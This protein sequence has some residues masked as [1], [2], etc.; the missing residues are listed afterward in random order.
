MTLVDSLEQIPTLKTTQD[1]M[2]EQLN[3]SLRRFA[4]WR[5]HSC[6]QGKSVEVGAAEKSSYGLNTTSAL[7]KGTLHSGKGYRVK[8]SLEKN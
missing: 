5:A 8:L 1:S 4:W 2:L 6:K 7:R 3:I